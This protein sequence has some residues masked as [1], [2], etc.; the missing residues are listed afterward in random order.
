MYVIVSRNK[1][2]SHWSLYWN[3]RCRVVRPWSPYSLLRVFI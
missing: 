2:I 3:S 1:Q